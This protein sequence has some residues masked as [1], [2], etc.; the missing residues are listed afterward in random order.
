AACPSKGWRRHRLNGGRGFCD[1]TRVMSRIAELSRWIQGWLTRQPRPLAA[2]I[3]LMALGLFTVTGAASWFAH[4][5]TAGLPSKAAVRDL[6]EMAQA[7]TILDARD[8]P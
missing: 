4:D 5:L 8:K 1:R 6:G 7:T 2:G 3:V